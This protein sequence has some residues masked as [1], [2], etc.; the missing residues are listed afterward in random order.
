M[1]NH[2]SQIDKPHAAKIAGEIVLGTI[3]AFLG[4]M[5]GIFFIYAL[6]LFLFRNVRV[7]VSMRIVLSFSVYIGIAIVASLAVYFAGKLVKH[8]S[9]YLFTLLGGG[10]GIGIY[11][12][13]IFIM[14]ALGF[15]PS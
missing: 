5:L 9:S 10:L 13:I 14:Y 3:G 7:P 11:T 4:Y 15:C 12:A 2:A 6:D 8:R 1:E